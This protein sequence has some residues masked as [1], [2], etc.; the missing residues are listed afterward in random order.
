MIRRSKS[1]KKYKERL[2]SVF[3]AYIR[4]KYAD[5]EGN[6]ECFTCGIVRPWQEM[7]AGHYHPR[8]A[9]LATYFEE[10]NVHPQCTGCNR[11]RHGNLTA[12]AI[13]LRKKYGEGILEEL[14][15]MRRQTRQIKENEYIEL[16]E[17][18][19]EKLK[20]FENKC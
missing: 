18:Y 6:T 2:W 17:A 14:D 3:S 4:Q 16:I 5:E 1:K 13:A 9:G 8:T 12:Y 10:K 20:M 11:F 19:K 15:Q 7:D